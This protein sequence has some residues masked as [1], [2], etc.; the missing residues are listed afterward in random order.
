[1]SI[2]AA[3]ASHTR[4]LYTQLLELHILQAPTT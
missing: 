4:G 2:R 3:S 1:M